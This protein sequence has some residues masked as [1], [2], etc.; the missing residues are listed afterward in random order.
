MSGARLV[1]GSHELTVLLLINAVLHLGEV[2]ELAVR[3]VFAPL[4]PALRCRVKE[5][6]GH[7]FSK[8]L[9]SLCLPSWFTLDLTSPWVE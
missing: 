9:R 7:V 2:A 6:N 8:F 5:T 4:H 3:G 1:E